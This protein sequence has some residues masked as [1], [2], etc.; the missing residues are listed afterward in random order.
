MAVRDRGKVSGCWDLWMQAQSQALWGLHLIQFGGNLI[1]KKDYK[2]KSHR[3]LEGAVQ[4]KE[5]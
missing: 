3:A 2:Y 5:P 4:V 1:K